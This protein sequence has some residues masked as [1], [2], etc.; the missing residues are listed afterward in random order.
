MPVLLIAL[1]LASAPASECQDA[2]TTIEMNNCVANTL[3]GAERQLDRYYDAAVQRL[4]SQDSPGARDA[5]SKLASAQA[6]WRTY[7]DAECA[8]VFDNWRDG[9]V[10]IAAET[11]CRIGAT[12][13]RTFS[14]WWSWLTYADSSA[15][16]LPR[17]DLSA[18]LTEGLLRGR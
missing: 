1:A 7:R 4:R 14:I 13:L 6:A 16:V 3:S 10:R 12:Q 17:P 8:A 15:P 9:S 11:K 2:K 5:L 18:T